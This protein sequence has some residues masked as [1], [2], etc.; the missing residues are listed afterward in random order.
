MKIPKFFVRGSARPNEAL[1]SSFGKLERE[2]LKEIWARGE[3]NVRQIVAAFDE[4]FA[5]TTVMTTLDRL[6]KK[7]VLTRRKEGKAFVYAARYTSEELETEF[8]E[9]VIG[10]LLDAGTHRIEPV[11][12]CI[13]DAVSDRD[14]ELLDRLEE[15]VR[16]KRR[17]LESEE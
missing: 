4:R 17:E 6:Y 13:V 12:A 1:I 2:I 3:V 10:C 16:E 7:G 5:Y 11:L 9:D 8:T 14:R 15:M